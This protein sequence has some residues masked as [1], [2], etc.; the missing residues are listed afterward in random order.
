MKPQKLVMNAFGPYAK[1]EEVDF[2]IFDS[3]IFLISGDTGSG[4]TTIFDA[5]SF[6]LYGEG[7]LG[8][9]K[10]TSKSY[11]SD[12][13]SKY[14]ETF[15]EFSF[16]HKE[17]LYKIIR[18]PEQERFKKKG[19]GLITISAKAI[20]YN[21]TNNQ[22]F[23]GVSEVNNKIFE[24]I[25]LDKE[26]FSQTVM[27]AQNDFMKILNSN[28][29]DR[30]E[31]LKKIFNTSLFSK[32]Q[33]SLKLK[34]KELND[35]YDDLRKEL[36]NLSAKLN[37]ENI[38]MA[39]IENVIDNLK[40]SNLILEQTILE[41]KSELN[42]ILNKRD[43]IQRNIKETIYKNDLLKRFEENTN[44][45]LKLEEEKPFYDDLN[46][47][48]IKGKWADE[49]L[50]IEKQI[51]TLT[52]EKSE[53]EEN[54]SKLVSENNNL[55]N[56]FKEVE[57]S[58][59]SIDNIK[60]QLVDKQKEELYFKE[61]TLLIDDFKDIDNK[62][63]IIKN[64]LNTTISLK[65]EKEI[66]LIELKDIFFKNQAGIIAKTL[67]DGEE[68]P[69]CG[70]IHHPKVATIINDVVS[71]EKVESLEDEV[72]NI[73]SKLNA[74]LLKLE[75]YRVKKEDILKKFSGNSFDDVV[76]KSN[77]LTKEINEL[78]IKINQIENLYNTLNN[79]LL[80][81][82]SSIQNTEINLKN[83]LNKIDVLD[84]K[85]KEKLIEYNFED[86]SNYKN[87]IL[88]KL[89]IAK[90]EKQIKDFEL[91]YISV[92]STTKS[93]NEQIKGFKFENIN[94]LKEQAKNLNNIFDEKNN[95]LINKNH[96]FETNN[97]YISELLKILKKYNL[98]KD[99]WNLIIELSNVVNGQKQN[100]IKITLETYVQ[101]HYFKQVVFAANKRLKKLS[102]DM[103]V[104][105]C[106]D[107]FNNKKS[108]T[109]LD[110]EVLDKNTGYYRDVNTMSGGETFIASLSLALGLS[111]IVQ[112]NSGQI[113]IESM[114]IDEGF[115]TLDEDSLNQ[116]INLL[117]SLS[118]SKILIGI[119]SH[120]ES[121]KNRINNK[122][123]I[124]KGI[125]GS[126]ITLKGD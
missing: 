88:D 62:V 80:V 115:G 74:E 57:K 23:E 6:A 19:D 100:S 81:N 60:K 65:K 73:E 5:I 126:K 1:T 93:L 68:C 59:L 48:V 97:N 32:I 49:I 96:E 28:S 87:H 114:F 103:F 39:N 8:N 44:K 72:K 14:D 53:L 47:K 106:K 119:I 70:S 94:Q 38:S 31:L 46:D 86:S 54:L 4:K 67:K 29:K 26:Q 117:N 83:I 33:D 110:L 24:I 42:E 75:G 109:G 121:L 34:S 22:V 58:F 69:V 55:N 37:F 16:F 41:T 107:D 25:G 45:L 101:R 116:A 99:D 27:I 79:K 108:Q 102:K 105:R 78:N 40:N 17:C 21:L 92:K 18:Y 111:D 20:L 12:Y 66:A 104:L 30:S 10:R 82:K 112:S 2:S 51:Q 77:I 89:E 3:G 118:D 84:T 56:D 90:L 43:V 123:L 120:V 76:I 15:V 64:N 124:T 36:N 52:S 98:K 7:S 122:I 13:S 35:F 11:R 85:F 63:E 61:L 50:Y 113:R 71:L 125:N 91:E 95:L 9:K